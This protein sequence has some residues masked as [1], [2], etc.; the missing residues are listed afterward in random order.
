[1]AL[2]VALLESP[3]GG[4][5]TRV[6]PL[7]RRPAGLETNATLIEREDVTPTIVRLRFRTEAAVP[8]FRA[9]QYFAIGIPVDGR[10]TQRPYST[11]STPGEREDP[12]FLIRLVPTGSLTP[13]LWRLRPGARVRIGPPK[14]RFTLDAGDRRR[15]V[16]LA[17]GTGIAPLLS[18]L[19]SLLHGS[20]GGAAGRDRALPPIVV[21]GVARVPELA[22]RERLERLATG[23]AIRYV[24][25]ISRPDDPANRGWLGDTGRLDGLAG[26]IA[27]QESLDPAAT[28]VYLC[29]N[30]A[31]I[32]TVEPRLAALGIPPSAIRAEQYWTPADRA[33][34]SDR[35]PGQTD[36]SGPPPS[37]CAIPP[38]A[39]G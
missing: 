23:G 30:P 37:P 14:G 7:A 21:H 38:G 11:A 5:T 34:A 3:G 6:T 25:A 20:H 32:A 16:F 28:V 17:T 22:Y 15:H 39:R 31:M 8:A 12:E 9:G 19:G 33:P 13:R 36:P 2:Q 10:W 35:D 4:V 1:M 24:P 29:G 18:M 26:R 27:E